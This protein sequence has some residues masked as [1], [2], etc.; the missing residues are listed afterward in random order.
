VRTKTIGFAIA[1]PGR[2]R[3]VRATPRRYTSPEQGRVTKA[4]RR[5][6]APTRYECSTS[7]H[8]ETPT[9]T[10]EIVNLIRA[11]ADI[12]RIIPYAARRAIAFARDP[13]PDCAG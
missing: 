12:Q 1:R 3:G 5:T 2:R 10:Q 8:D 7:P 11:T 13:R 6:E 4:R 9:D